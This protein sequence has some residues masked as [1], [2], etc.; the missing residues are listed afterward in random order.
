MYLW[1]KIAKQKYHHPKPTCLQN[2]PNPETQHDQYGPPEV[3]FLQCALTLKVRIS[4]L[5]WRSV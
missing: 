1:K 2:T 3:P 5:N 4:A